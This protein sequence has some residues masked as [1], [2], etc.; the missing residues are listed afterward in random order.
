MKQSNH[1]F[2]QFQISK[3]SDI[4][5]S[6]PTLGERRPRKPKKVGFDNYCLIDQY[7]DDFSLPK[8][9]EDDL[10]KDEDYPDQDVEDNRQYCICNKPSN[11]NMVA[12]DNENCK[13]KGF[14]YECVNF[15]P[16][17]EYDKWYCPICLQQMS[18]NL[19]VC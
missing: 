3:H 19:I 6:Q 11:D 16:K 14:H 13:I 17:K 5:S 7:G 10:R 18:T 4:I 9:V 12:C 15:D 8:M 1:D 2:S